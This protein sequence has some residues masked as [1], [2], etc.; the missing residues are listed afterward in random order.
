MASSFSNRPPEPWCG[1]LASHVPSAQ[2]SVPAS[3]APSVVPASEATLDPNAVSVQVSPDDEQ[4]MAANLI[5]N[6]LTV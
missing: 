4:M 6:V 2:Q 3:Y 1:Q 5:G